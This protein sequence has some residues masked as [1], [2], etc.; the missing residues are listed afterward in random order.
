MVPS[1]AAR[2]DVLLRS[3]LAQVERRPPSLEPHD[4][5]LA[6]AHAAGDR[7]LEANLLRQRARD[8]IAAGG[9]VDLALADYA[10]GEAGF[11]ALGI[12]P[13]LA[14]THAEHGLLLAQE[15]RLDDA[16]DQ[17]VQGV[18]LYEE[19]GMASAAEAARNALANR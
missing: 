7:S 4:H 13:L 16:R 11:E 14:E 17:L 3:A 8:R 15:G 6:L 12:R 10:A 18:N 19:M 2:C 9:S 1:L 5:A